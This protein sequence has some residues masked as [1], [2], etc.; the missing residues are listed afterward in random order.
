MCMCVCVCAR[1]RA[2]VRVVGGGGI[3]ELGHFLNPPYSGKLAGHV[4]KGTKV[5]EFEVAHRLGLR[6]GSVRVG[7]GPIGI[8]GPKPCRE[9]GCTHLHPIPTVTY[10]TGMGLGPSPTRSSRCYETGPIPVENEYVR[11]GTMPYKPH[12][13]P[14]WEGRNSR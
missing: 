13:R 9:R 11:V 14:G 7:G 10:G 8:P 4:I 1:A 6:N 12:P 3:E 5:H 2:R